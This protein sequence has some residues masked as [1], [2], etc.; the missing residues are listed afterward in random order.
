MSVSDRPLPFR[1]D[2][3]APRLS[4]LVLAP[5]RALSFWLAVVLPVAYLPL[6]ATGFGSVG[7]VVTFAT[8]VA[9]HVCTLV[10][11]RSYSRCN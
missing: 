5:V 6:L 3:L 7:T 1:A 10:V 4:K 11:G 9:V 8:L 2:A